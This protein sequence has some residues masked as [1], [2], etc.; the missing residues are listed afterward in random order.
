MF[1]LITY[2][3]SVALAINL[4]SG[5]LIPSSATSPYDIST[6]ANDYVTP[7]APMARQPVK[8]HN[9]RDFPDHAD[10]NYGM[11]WE[12]VHAFCNSKEPTIL[13]TLH[14][15][16]DGRFPVTFK[17]RMRWKDWPHQINYDFF[18]EWVWGCR[19]T[20]QFQSVGLPLGKGGVNCHTIMRE[21]YLNCNN[22]GVGGSTQVGCLLFTFNGAKGGRCIL[23]DDEMELRDE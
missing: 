16:A 12:A 9:E 4:V 2:L 7:L 19:T 23:T 14:D 6:R 17:H 1:L 21:N 8:C 20:S 13:S 22:G 3:A 18:V 5:L 15:P 11:Q 10:V